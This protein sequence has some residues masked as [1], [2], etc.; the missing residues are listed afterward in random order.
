MNIAQPMSAEDDL[1]QQPATPARSRLRQRSSMVIWAGRVGALV[2]A[3]GLWQLAYSLKLTSRTVL[4]S[5]QS[6][7]DATTAMQQS[8]ALW[9]NLWSTIEAS[10]WALLLAA[11]IGVPVGILLGM[12]PRTWA[13]FGPYLNAL[14]SMPRIALAP[15]FIVVFGIGQS[16]KVALGFS[17][18][19]FI[20]IMN[21]RIGVLSTDEEH[22]TVC[23]T[24]G[25]TKFQ[26]FRKLYLPVA[27][28]A[29]FTAIRLGM[30]Y[31]LLGV[32]SAEIISSRAGMGQL[33]ANYSATLSMS[34]VYSALIILAIFASILT[35]LAGTAENLL[36]RWQRAGN[37]G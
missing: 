5:P 14:N 33:I 30:V 10:I 8:G 22:R 24:L 18:A 7:W 34:Y 12:L 9:T 37:Q 26:L 19:V 36:L 20:F 16:A 27:I 28:P 17:I 29:V 11:V 21:A 23:L 15:V 6:V 31:A 3:V 32:V 2:A 4:P 1:N 25:A 13:V 35:V